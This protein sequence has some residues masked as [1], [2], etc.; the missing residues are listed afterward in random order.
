MRIRQIF[1][2]VAVAASAILFAASC[3]TVPK[4]IPQDLSAQE[5]IQRAQEASD[6]YNYKAAT[7]YYQALI[8]RFGSDQAYLCEGDYELAFIAYKEDRLADAQ[9]GFEKLLALYSSPDG[10]SL[11][12][13]YKILGEKV[14]A[15]VK[16]LR[17]GQK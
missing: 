17:A 10:D 5:I 4:S 12:Q 1:I 9:A 16:E 13:A 6:V 3:A 15:H 2:G 7:V 14:L 11:P 8:D